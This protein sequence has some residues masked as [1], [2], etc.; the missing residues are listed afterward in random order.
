MPKFTPAFDP[1]AEDHHG[2]V[3]PGCGRCW[4]WRVTAVVSGED[5]Y[6]PLGVSPIRRARSRS[7]AVA[8][9]A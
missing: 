4:V 9:A 7:K 5:D 3:F 1:V 2:G 6:I 8:A